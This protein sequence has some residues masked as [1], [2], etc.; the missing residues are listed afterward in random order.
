VPRTVQCFAIQEEGGWEAFCLD[1]DLAVQGRSFAE[2]E[3][4]LDEAISLYL[5]EVRELPSA[6]QARLLARRAPLLLRL[7]FAWIV[8]RSLVGRPPGATQHHQFTLAAA[9]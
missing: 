2:V 3:A 7:R 6:D 4:L 8:L 5:E 9:I 1:F